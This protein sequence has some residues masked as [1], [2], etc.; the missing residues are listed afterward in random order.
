MNEGHQAREVADQG[1]CV[2]LV[3]LGGSWGQGHG[4]SVLKETLDQVDAACALKVCL[5]N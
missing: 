4:E 2:A 5:E 3:P 1:A